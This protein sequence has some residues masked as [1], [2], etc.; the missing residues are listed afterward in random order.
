MTPPCTVCREPATWQ[1]TMLGFDTLILPICSGHML[2]SEEPAWQ[3]YQAWCESHNIVAFK[4]SDFYGSY[5]ET[6]RV[7]E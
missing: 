3:A 4:R 5:V 2:M 6:L 1:I 7:A